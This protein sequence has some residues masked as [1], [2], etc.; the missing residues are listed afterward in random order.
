LTVLLLKI[1]LAPVLIGLVSLAGRRWGPGVSGW[2]LGLPLN[3]AP[4]FLFLLMEQGPA[5]AAR[6]AVGTLLGILAWAAFTLVYAYCCLRLPWWWS[7]IAGWIAF[8]ALAWLLIPVNAGVIWVFFLVCATLAVVLMLFPLV[9]APTSQAFH[10]NSELWLR[11]A[12]AGAMVTSLTTLA[13]VLG[14]GA[15][16]VLSAFPAFTTILAVFNHRHHPAAAVRVLKGLS[17]GLYT[18]AT[19]FLVLTLSIPHFAI[20]PS[21]AFASL[22][23]LAV[24]AASLVYVRRRA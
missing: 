11:M 19:F 21:F 14:P 1:I 16:G 8:S 9:E 18:S 24:Q 13:K 23:A 17:A 5:F 15:S 3:S 12:I 4:I 10:S 22:A 2:L 6:A 7:T 20:A